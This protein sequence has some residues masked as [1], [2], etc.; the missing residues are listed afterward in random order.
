[1]DNVLSDMTINY[2]ISRYDQDKLAQIG[3]FFFFSQSKTIIW[4]IDNANSM[5]GLTMPLIFEFT[6][7]IFQIYHRKLSILR[8]ERI[9][10]EI[11]YIY[12]GNVTTYDHCL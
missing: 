11:L 4:K 7:S 3:V 12:T 2:N 10:I 8:N 6:Y 5:S 1:M 9:L